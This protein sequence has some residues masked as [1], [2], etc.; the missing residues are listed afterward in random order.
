MRSTASIL[1]SASRT[2]S[3]AAPSTRALK[4]LI[5]DAYAPASREGFRQ[6][7]MPTAGELYTQMLKTVAPRG[8]DVQCTVIHPADEDFEK[9]DVGEYDGLAFSGSSFSVYDDVPGVRKQIDLTH[10]AFDKQVPCFGSCWGLQIL[11]YAAGAAVELNPRGRE[12]GIGRKISLTTEGRAHPLFQG[13][14]ATFDAFIS[15]S[16]E[17]VHMSPNMIN[18]AGNDHSRVQALALNINNCEHWAVQYHPEYTL[19]YISRM[20]VSRTERLM[21][22]GFFKTEEDLKSFS[23]DLA[24]IDADPTRFDL[25]WKY[26][27]D[28]DVLDPSIMLVEP[29]NWIKHL[30]SLPSKC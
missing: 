13:K 24:E 22:M 19:G 26:G 11:A 21:N 20:T 17:V 2:Y 16:D 25:K 6:F 15:H 28:A 1:R 4:V 8:V 29:R 3:T 18:L 30:L 23:A 14:K 9:P 27:I 10:E 12:Y 5:V 7:N